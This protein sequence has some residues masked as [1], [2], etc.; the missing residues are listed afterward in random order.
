MR[1]K[2]GAWLLLT[3]IGG[4]LS[5]PVNAQ[6][7]A[8]YD[9]G[10]SALT[11]QLQR[12]Q[13]TASVMHTGAHPDDEDS[14][15]VAYHARHLN[16][17]TA[18]LSLT[19]GSGGQNIIGTEQSDA[20]GVIRT[21]ELLQ[22]RRLDG[23]EQLFTRA[24]DFGFSKY[25]TEA[26]RIWPEEAVL[27]DMVRAIRTF[28]PNVV[29]SRWN[30]TPSDG[31]GHHQFTGYLTPLAVEAAA[32]PDQFP[33][34]IAAGLHPWQ[35]QKLYTG[36]RI[37]PR[38]TDRPSLM[39]NTGTYD[40]V[41]GRSYFEIGMQGR[42]QQKTQ[43]MGALELRG[44]Q[45]SGLQ[46]VTSHL[47]TSD[48][49]SSVFTGID[50]SINGLATF[51]RKA[52]ASFTGL[53]RELQ[54][55]AAD[56]LSQYDPLDPQA[57]IPQ[58]VEGLAIA[59]ASRDAAE[60]AD[61]Q[62]LLDEKIQEFESALMLAAGI[63]L[64]ALADSETVVPGSTLTVAVRTFM[65]DSAPVTL[66][67]VEL[68]VPA[69]W[70]VAGSRANVLSSESAYRRREQP[71]TEVLYDVTV[72]VDARPTQPYWLERPRDAAAYDWSTAGDARNQPFAA[73]LLIA[74]ARL[75]IGDAPITVRKEVEY[76]LVDRVRGEIR[77]R[78][79][80]VP[81]ISVEPAADLLV[82]PASSD[83]ER[84][85][86][87][88]TLRNNAN[89]SIDG[90]AQ[91][92]LPDGWSLE[93]SSSAFS[94]PAAPA[95]TT[96]T[97]SATLPDDVSAGE[98]G[99]VASATIDGTA[100]RQAM[101]E[102]SYPHIRT[103]RLYDPSETEFEVVDVEVAP[104]RIGY[105]MGSGDKVP[106]AL[107]RL[108]LDVSLLTDAELTTGDL[109]DFDTIVIGIRASQTRPAY[110]A[111]NRRLL[112]F[113]EQ[114]GSLIVQYQQPDFI[115][116]GL[117]PYPASM[118]GN[119]RVVDETAP[120]VILE[121]DHPVFAYPNRID[122]RDF[123]GWVQERNNYNFTSFDRNRYVPLTEAHDEGEPE[124]EGG[125]VYAK[126]GS[127]HYVYTSYSWFRQLPNGVPGAYR[128]FANLLSL[129]AAP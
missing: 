107:R 116:K 73:P 83:R 30:G 103:H 59:R 119:V 113:A 99:L 7:R 125:M 74:V 126:I 127:G 114:G 21:E 117:A 123:D 87:L 18:Y 129:P 85:E 50:T 14:A 112:D 88:L 62:R 55:R 33:D 48:A 4:T 15:L 64:D 128:V 111:N 76:R 92:A 1:T 121:P 44:R 94:L 46:L 72:P 95:T 43:Q 77:R 102:I 35:V 9:Q 20:L 19:R 34:Q 108:G 11:R 63:S 79:D 49:E 93:P 115:A 54:K 75:K 105:V 25:R 70:L 24:N 42:S 31:H 71:D 2:L 47:D 100:Y 91:F 22:A 67:D 124:S 36:R 51:E 3:L 101:R 57:L 5:F 78:I 13:T 110:V 27:G 122:A 90:T 96:L 41:T 32:D 86:L 28:R 120:I 45:L 26:S 38:S 12:L 68:E 97:F 10:G 69:N 29:V 66:T 58:L 80:V 8:I 98:Y 52:T 39:V 53:L 16:A 104:V 65:P 17:R 118:D 82:L 106:E 81:A 6:V 40:P 84:H 23:A 60:G 109:A 56:A 89:E 61:T 37:D